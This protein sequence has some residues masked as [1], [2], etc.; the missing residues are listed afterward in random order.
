MNPATGRT[1]GRTRGTPAPGST[2]R[3]VYG[4]HPSQ[5]LEVWAP[6]ESPDPAPTVVL[7]HGGYWRSRWGRD[8]MVPLAHDLLRRGRRVV[9]VGYRRVGEVAVGWRATFADVETALECSTVAAPDREDHEPAPV[10]LVGHSAGGQL[11]L[12]VTS[13]RP[14]LVAGVVAL[15]PVADLVEAHRRH[16][17]RDAVVGLLGGTPAE[18]PDRYRAASPVE[19]VA[20]GRPTLVVHGRADRDVPRDLSRRYVAAA[21]AAGDPVDALWPRGVDHFDLI[22]PG[23]GVWQDTVDWLTTG[24]LTAGAPPASRRH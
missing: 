1:A 11:A 5:V 22:D 3:I 12:W 10:Q 14:E 8:L 20:L 9:V 13:R 21:A 24:G 6:G 17:S 23:H 7:L 16:L 18:V 19:L 15:A 2:Q 4:E